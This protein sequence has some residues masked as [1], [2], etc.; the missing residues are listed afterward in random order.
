MNGAEAIAAKGAILEVE[1]E[2]VGD[3]NRWFLRAQRKSRGAQAA[4]LLAY[5]IDAIGLP[6]Y[7]DAGW[8]TLNPFANVWAFLADATS[9][10]PFFRD[11]E[12]VRVGDWVVSK[13][14]LRALGSAADW[15]KRDGQPLTLERLIVCLIWESDG[16]RRL[17]NFLSR[18]AGTDRTLI[19]RAIL[20][21]LAGRI[22][23][24]DV[25]ETVQA[26]DEAGIGSPLLSLMKVAN[27]TSTN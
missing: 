19:E 9:G 25:Q 23:K 26:T 1:T 17:V 27:R 18:V 5:G 16:A 24:A 22:A 4:E 7:L 21:F 11:W 2:L 10:M 20:H 3:F 14:L 13:D 12:T 8:G 6:M 15:A